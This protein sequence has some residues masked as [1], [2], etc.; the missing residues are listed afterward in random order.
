MNHCSFSLL[1]WKILS[2]ICFT[3][4]H[5]SFTRQVRRDQSRCCGKMAEAIGAPSQ[6]CDGHRTA[7]WHQRMENPSQVRFRI[8]TAGHHLK[9]IVFNWS[10]RKWQP[11]SKSWI[12]ISNIKSL[13]YSKILGKIAWRQLFSSDSPPP[14]ILMFNSLGFTQGPQAIVSD[15][16]QMFARI[17]INSSD[18]H[19]P[20][21][22]NRLGK[23]GC[24]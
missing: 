16:P 14:T 20:G 24:T 7:S 5:F 11:S 17:L 23:I 15:L 9:T 12:R 10:W 21:S 19:S 18:P 3:L 6:I 8:F 4:T 22:N 1:S 13:G 2:L